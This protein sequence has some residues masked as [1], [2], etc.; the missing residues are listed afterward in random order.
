MNGTEV[1]PE[2]IPGENQGV[3][4]LSKVGGGCKRKAAT[5]LD[6]TKSN[7]FFGPKAGKWKR[8]TKDGAKIDSRP[9]PD[10]QLQKRILAIDRDWQD[11]KL[12]IENGGNE[13]FVI[14]NDAS[15]VG[16]YRHAN[17]YENLILERLGCEK[18]LGI[19]S[20]A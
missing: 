18:Y 14:V 20:L 5:E 16:L 4:E 12:K 3:E 13:A 17:N 6:S 7:N 1:N 15:V 19:P 2:N 10:T 9:E 11:K 8:W